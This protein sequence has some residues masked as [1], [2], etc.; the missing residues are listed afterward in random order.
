MDHFELHFNLSQPIICLNRVI[1][2]S[3]LRWLQA[4]EICNSAAIAIMMHYRSIVAKIALSLSYESGQKN[5][6]ELVLLLQYGC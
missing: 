2:S 6:K 3:K 5:L 4:V 1:R